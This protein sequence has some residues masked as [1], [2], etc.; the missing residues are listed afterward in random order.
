M[1]LKHLQSSFTFNMKRFHKNIRL[2]SHT[3][4]FGHGQDHFPATRF[5]LFF[6]CRALWSKPHAE[7]P[8]HGLPACLLCSFVISLLANEQLPSPSS[9]AALLQPDPPPFGPSC[10]WTQGATCWLCHSPVLEGGLVSCWRPSAE[11]QHQ[12]AL[13]SVAAP[14]L[15]SQR[16]KACGRDHKDRVLDAKCLYN[17]SRANGSAQA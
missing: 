8:W 9:A 13:L 7:Q 17:I 12:E 3:V 6:F 10:P 5:W 14:E 2:V 4:G 1:D 11:D 16:K 15:T